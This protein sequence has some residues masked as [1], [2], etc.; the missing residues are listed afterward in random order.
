MSII[1]KAQTLTN[2]EF[3][4]LLLK[5]FED[6][7]VE[8]KKQISKSLLKIWLNLS[9]IFII[10]LSIYYF[11]LKQPFFFCFIIY[12]TFMGLISCML[13]NIYDMY[14]YM[15]S[16]T[17]EDFNRDLDSISIQA[18]NRGKYITT[19]QLECFGTTVQKCL[20]DNEDCLQRHILNAL[21]SKDN[22]LQKD[23]E[24]DRQTLISQNIKLHVRLKQ[25]KSNK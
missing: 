1:E 6:K 11:L 15:D 20:I 10:L 14:D 13:T 5:L 21:K 8:R 3:Y 22:P 9:I 25:T 24:T 7:N 23:I 19:H 4:K 18:K 16:Y 17:T 12:V 2:R